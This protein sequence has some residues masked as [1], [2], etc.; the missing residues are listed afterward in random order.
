MKQICTGQIAEFAVTNSKLETFSVTTPKMADGTIT[1][2]KPAESF[3]K[4]VTLNDDAAGNALGWKPDGVINGFFI[5][6]PLISSDQNEPFFI[7]ESQ[8][9]CDVREHNA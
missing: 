3:M 7:V 4:R 6:E 9:L 8:S 1:S 5:F 2:T